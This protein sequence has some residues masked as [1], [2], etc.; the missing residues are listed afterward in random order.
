MRGDI[1]VIVHSLKD[2]P[3]K[4]PAGCAV[5]SVGAREF[6]GDVLVLR[7]KADD[8]DGAGSAGR[9]RGLAG[10]QDG[11]VIG[12]S[13]V[14]RAAM[15]RRRYPHLVI[16]DVRG[17]VPTRI[18]K[19][20]DE[21]EGFDALV[22]A[23]AGVQRL[24]LGARV[25]CELG[26]GEGVLGSVGQGALGVEFRDGEGEGAGGLGEGVGKEGERDQWIK[27]LVEGCVHRRVEWETRAERSLLRTV[28]GGCSVPVG[29][30]T[31]WTEEADETTSSS[32]HPPSAAHAEPH[33]NPNPNPDPS[34]TT[35]HPPSAKTSERAVLLMRA[36]VVSLDGKECVEAERRR[37]I[38]SDADAEEAGWE[39]AQELVGKGAGEIL[40][41]I[42]LNRGMIQG[43]DGA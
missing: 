37:I 36:M 23:G 1:D 30:E 28:E 38:G 3:T 43:M 27:S 21:S 26:R 35:P 32:Q 6:P 8:E 13:S 42:T 16:K 24:G 40:E 11:A 39:M 10:M 19:L 9:K 33:T 14:R 2:V 18:R 17:N 7:Q 34:T 31:S 5:R 25:E 20:D 22:L 12:T 4:L 41:A 15:I 29:V